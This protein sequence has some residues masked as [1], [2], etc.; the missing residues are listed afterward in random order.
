M[1]IALQNEVKHTDTLKLVLTYMSKSQRNP[2]VL[3]D[4]LY[5]KVLFVLMD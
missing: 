5:S 2:S 3:V 4:I 1:H